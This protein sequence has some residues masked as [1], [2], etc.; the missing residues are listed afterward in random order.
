MHLTD[1]ENFEINTNTVIYYRVYYEINQWDSK[2]MASLGCVWTLLHPANDVP[3]MERP[4]K[5]RP[6]FASLDDSLGCLNP[7]LNMEIMMEY[8]SWSASE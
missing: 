5:W 7:L 8:E 4:F 2:F 1:F 3:D 6:K